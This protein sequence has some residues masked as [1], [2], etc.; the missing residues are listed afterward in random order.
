M[1]RPLK[2]A[3]TTAFAFS[4][5][6]RPIDKQIINV[7][8]SSVGTSQV[9][10]DLFTATFP[11]TITGIRWELSNANLLTTGTPRY[12]WAIVLL[13]D[14]ETA[15]V[16]SSSNASSFYQ[17]EQ[18]VLSWSSGLVRDTDI[19]GGPTIKYDSGSTKTMRKLMGGDKIIFIAIASA[20]S[21]LLISGSVQFFCKT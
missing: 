21:S 7:D 19:G 16:M 17:P 4:G 10:T 18:N 11:C 12:Q 3:R 15:S 13:R 14:G 5:P 2:R 9:Q 8:Q 20:A 6:K 1:S